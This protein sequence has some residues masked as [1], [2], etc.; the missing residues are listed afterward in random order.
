MVPIYGCSLVAMAVFLKKVS[1]LR[2]A[3]LQHTGWFDEA[4]GA[5][6]A[7]SDED[8]HQILRSAAHP[9]ARVL[10]AG[11][12]VR[13]VSSERVEA[14][15]RRVGNLELQR[16]EAFLPV[17]SFIAQAAPLLGLLGTVLGMVDL[18][19]G[20]QAG[21]LQTIDLAKLSSGIWKALLTTAAGL[22]V[23]LPTLAG[24]AYLVR[25]AEALRIQISDLVQR[26]LTE[27]ALSAGRK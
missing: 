19:Q 9:A 6:R 20:L 2:S 22:S 7:G 24:H 25:K 5:I 3:R 17:L 14:E 16:A 21:G 10:D 15:A 23:A 18:F 4:M 1:D 11:L 8:I 26:T 13:H 12:S 27:M